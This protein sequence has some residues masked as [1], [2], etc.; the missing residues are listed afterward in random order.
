MT[1]EEF[2][3]LALLLRRGE[4]LRALGVGRNELDG[5]VRVLGEGEDPDQAIKEAIRDRCILAQRL[6]GMT[7]LRY[8][9]STVEPLVG[10]MR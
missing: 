1:P 10:V 7:R 5:L 8:I 6:R 4:V 9:K 2:S 3:E